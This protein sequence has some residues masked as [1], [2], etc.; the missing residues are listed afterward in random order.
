MKKPLISTLFAFLLVHGI[1]FAQN[2]RV[3]ISKLNTSVKIKIRAQNCQ[4]I[5]WE[6]FRESFADMELKGA[7]KFTF[8]IEREANS[9]KD[10]LPTIT[11]FS[12]T[13]RKPAKVLKRAEKWC[14]RVLSAGP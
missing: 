1:C 6:K 2:D 8:E 12:T 5:D 11:N 4:D 3:K 9:V 10:G 7:K 13:G 14:G